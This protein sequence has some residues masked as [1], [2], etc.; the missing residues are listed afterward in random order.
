[1]A[2]RHN[3]C[4]NPAGA[5][6][7]TGWGGN[8]VPAQVAGL[9]GMSRTVGLR[10]TGGT[11]ATSPN[12]AANPGD[13]ITVSLDVLTETTSDPSIDLYFEING[14]TQVGAVVNFALT[15]GIPERVSITRTCPVGTVSMFLVVDSFNGASSPF[16][17]TG[18]LVEVAPAAGSY[19]DGTVPGAPTSSWDGTPELSASTLL[20]SS[21]ATDVDFAGSIPLQTAGLLVTPPIT[22]SP[23]SWI[24]AQGLPVWR[25]SQG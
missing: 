7:I 24:I 2:T 20:D 6:A 16:V 9:A 13:V 19:F 11:F 1:M 3:L 10:W 23:M 18:V 22:D 8:A 5:A 25:I 14:G 12:V 21:P 15:A 17:I 4:P